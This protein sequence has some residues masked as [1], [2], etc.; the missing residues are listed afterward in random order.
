M[1]GGQI[2]PELVQ[3]KNFAL[4]AGVPMSAVPTMGRNKEFPFIYQLSGMIFTGF[5]G[6]ISLLMIINE[7]YL[8]DFVFD[9][10][11]YSICSIIVSLAYWG[12]L[13][14]F[15]IMAT[16]FPDYLANDKP[17]IFKIWPI[18]VATFLRLYWMLETTETK[19]EVLLPFMLGRV[20]IFVGFYYCYFAGKDAW[21]LGTIFRP[22]KNE[23]LEYEEVKDAEQV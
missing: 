17:E 22:W 23:K 1:K 16:A 5:I 19:I 4:P 21:P 14:Y 11:F 20:S 7:F 15:S 10:N 9:I 8:P 13:A 3:T 12:L 18:A 2:Y 6:L